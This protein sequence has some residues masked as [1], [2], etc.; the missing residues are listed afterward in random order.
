M[1]VK[2]ASRLT[3][4]A[5]LGRV[6]AGQFVHIAVVDGMSRVSGDSVARL[7]YY[8]GSARESYGW[9]WDG[10]TLEVT[11]DR[12]GCGPL[13]WSG[14]QHRIRVA[15]SIPLLL[16]QGASAEPDDD[17]MAVFVRLGFFLGEDTPFAGIRAMPPAGRLTWRQ[18]TLTLE[19][20]RITGR[21]HANPVFDD[22]V[23]E[24]A[25]LFRDAMAGVPFD[26][27]RSIVP[28]SGGKDSRHIFLELHASDRAPVAVPT[29]EQLPWQEANLDVPI[30]AELT[31]RTHVRHVVLQQPADPLAAE[32]E[33]NLL[34]SYCSDEHT[35]V[36]ALHGHLADRHVIL[37]DG[38]AGD[39]LSE[40]KVRD[41][42]WSNG[43]ARGDVAE[44][45]AREVGPAA[46]IPKVLQ[47]ELIRRWSQE[48]ALARMQAELAN[49]IADP[50]P[51]GAYRFWS[52]ARREVALAPLAMLGR[53][54]DVCLPY[55]YP[56]LFEFLSG[57]PAAFLTSH[58]IHTA[59]MRRAY[60]QFA[61]IPFDYERNSPPAAAYRQS[62]SSAAAL[63]QRL[64]S[65]RWISS[66]L[67]FGTAGSAWIAPGGTGLLS[68]RSVVQPQHPSLPWLPRMLVLVRMVEQAASGSAS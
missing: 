48:R 1:T 61:D 38:L 52:R 41:P 37:Y 28:L 44:T 33:K 57:L 5:P 65:A 14:D 19:G 54:N 7:G 23:D 11:S 29:F 30:A 9:R 31:R 2:V 26:Q 35:H 46:Y 50:N 59:A 47:P 62:L 10:E 6:D 36:M 53:G 32:I 12:Y 42:S 24:Y 4:T 45:A 22:V 3:A 25:R 15:T 68:A 67:R 56:P 39:V 21:L 60:P 64:H 17:A 20:S 43:L 51:F 8:A 16:S 55:L 63:R 58:R 49:Y 66:A 13:F 40:S 34:C 27:Q 18:G